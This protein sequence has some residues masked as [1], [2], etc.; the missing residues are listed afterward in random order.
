MYYPDD[1]V[2]E[3]RLRSDIVDIIGSYVHLRKSG[4][5]HVGLCP[6][7]NEKTGSF[8]VNGQ[9]QIFKC[10]GCGVGGNVITFL[11]KYDNMTFPEA[12]KVLADRAG[13]ALPE[14]DY[15]EEEKKANSR[16]Q[17]ILQVNKEAAKYYFAAL[18]SPQG[19]VG[20]DYFYGR[21][22]SDDTIKNFGLG[23]A[24]SGNNSLYSYL[25]V[26]PDHFSDDVLNASGIFNFSEKYGARDKFWNRVIF[27]IMDVNSK[28]IA[29]GGRLMSAGAVEEGDKKIPKYL[30]SPE[31]DVF[32]KSRNLYGLNISR[33]SRS[34]YLI[35]CEGYMD[36]IAL[37]QAGFDMAVAS[38]GTAFTSGHATLIRRFTKKVYLSYDSDDAGVKAALRALPILK[39]AGI[40]ARVIDMRPYK[41][42]DEFIKNLGREE[43][44]KRIDNAEGSFFYE[45]RMLE[46]DYDLSDPESKTNFCVEIAGRISR[47]DEEIE[48]TNYI[49]AICSKYGLSVESLS[50]L[51]AK[52]AMKAENMPER[53][54]IRSGIREREKEA[55]KLDVAKRNT[56]KILLS[57]ICD[58][59]EI[60]GIVS[61]YIKPTDF[62][63]SLYIKAAELLYEQISE[64]PKKI[65]VARIIGCFTDE[66]EQTEVASLFSSSKLDMSDEEKPEAL[67][68][69][70][71]KILEQTIERINRLS[72][73]GDIE[74]ISRGFE[75]KQTVE[76]LKRMG[77][78]KW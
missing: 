12:I 46:R 47:L 71:I 2:E 74:A 35:L 32:D 53:P 64:D 59:P 30:N 66:E 54:V 11:M 45:I 62:S 5:N 58:E 57:W 15:S 39:A 33:R 77:I 40:S 36:V 19:K 29:F 18:K 48:R 51:V 60:F 22:L 67:K 44:Q 24:A 8:S 37:H 56:Q 31:T 50:K 76:K 3:I 75:I 4:A 21:G 69:L 14:I 25:K 55:D 1:L 61:E 16:K 43:Y 72:Q 63:G 41:D 42:P 28:V 27:P 17:Q 9:R 26:L 23:F 70:I 34:G 65:N 13:V 6:F 52:Q 49:E 78:K 68:R 10:F 38:L 7:H 20:L 73:D